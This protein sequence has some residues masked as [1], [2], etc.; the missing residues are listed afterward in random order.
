ML[1]F[2]SQMFKLPVEVFI[3]G[4]EVLTWTMREFQ[5]LFDGTI[6]TMMRELARGAEPSAAG[7][8][9]PASEKVDEGRSLPGPQIGSDTQDP[10]KTKEERTMTDRDLGG[11]NVKTVR[12]RIIFTKRNNETTLLEREDTV[13]Y[14]ADAMGLSGRKIA[15]LFTRA[16][17]GGALDE[18][19]R[20]LAAGYKDLRDPDY[21]N[22]PIAGP[23]W[24][25][26]WTLKEEDKK[27]VTF[28]YEVLDQLP[29]QDAEYDRQQVDV[30]RDIK[31]AID[32]L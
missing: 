16:A 18:R 2:V 5:Q 8:P 10:E 29:K 12:Y 32:N 31:S 15:D 21:P 3:S 22:D 24:P 23:P 26:N 14:A 13:N 27:Y 25:D 7:L 17:L 20:L 30:L 28:R 19:N 4:M 6:D 1:R 9:T 11:D